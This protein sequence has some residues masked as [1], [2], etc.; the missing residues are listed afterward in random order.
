LI[1]VKTNYPY[2]TFTLIQCRPLVIGIRLVENT[3]F[4]HHT[5]YQNQWN[6]FGGVQKDFYCKH[7]IIIL[8]GHLG[9]CRIPLDMP[10]IFTWKHLS[11]LT[12]DADILF[13]VPLGT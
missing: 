8:L 10:N 7:L 1:E 5:M 3:C 4:L 2:F 12:C 13:T 9:V 6:L 11:V